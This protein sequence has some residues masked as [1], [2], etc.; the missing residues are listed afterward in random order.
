[1][2]VLDI[3]RNIC[4]FFVLV[5]ALNWGTFGILDV[6]IITVFFGDI[7]SKIVC[8]IIA[9]SGLYIILLKASLRG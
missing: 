5:G 9:L 7:L 8:G 1:M 4:Q 2:V 3:I 6:N